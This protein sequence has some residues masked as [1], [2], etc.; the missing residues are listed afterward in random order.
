M[1]V[2][3]SE[4][5]HLIFK[6]HSLVYVRVKESLILA[7]SSSLEEA[8]TVRHLISIPVS[9]YGQHCAT[10]A[11]MQANQGSLYIAHHVITN[12]SFP[13]LGISC[14]YWGLECTLLPISFFQS[15]KPS[16]L[17]SISTTFRKNEV[18]SDVFHSVAV[19]GTLNAMQLHCLVETNHLSIFL[20]E[21]R[22]DSGLRMG[23]GIFK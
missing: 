22:N 19:I 14:N 23:A 11:A 18:T 12:N 1:H 17:S 6:N 7:F 4:T 13:I 20:R 5:V 2:F 8:L 10:L 9:I 15:W 16:D 21:C 3:F